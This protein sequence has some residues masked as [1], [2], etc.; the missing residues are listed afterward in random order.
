MLGLQPISQF[1]FGLVIMYHFPVLVSSDSMDICHGHGLSTIHASTS[2][3]GEG[4]HEKSHHAHHDPLESFEKSLKAI[5]KSIQSTKQTTKALAGAVVGL[6]GAASYDA[7]VSDAATAV[8]NLRSAHYDVTK[9]QKIIDEQLN[10]PGDLSADSDLGANAEDAPDDTLAESAIPTLRFIELHSIVINRNNYR[11]FFYSFLSVPDH[12]ELE[13]LVNASI[14]A[15]LA[16]N[17]WS[18]EWFIR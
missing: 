5:L 3:Q 7:L 6:R 11:K 17:P 2:F 13:T 10:P 12:A 8:K 1:F 9:A 4:F 18:C 14:F 16:P 15:R